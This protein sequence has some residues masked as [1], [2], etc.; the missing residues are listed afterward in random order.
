MKIGVLKEQKKDENRVALQPFQVKKLTKLG[1]EVFVETNAGWNSGFYDPEY[2]ESGAVVCEKQ[3][4]LDNA[5]LILKIKAPLRSEFCNYKPHHA[6]FTYL[7]F[8]ENM[9]PADITSIVSTG[10]TAIAYEWVE[11]DGRYPLLEPMS[12]LTGYLFAQKSVELCSKYK[13]KLCGCYEKNMN[14][15]GKM[16][17]I[18]IGNIGQSA[19]NYAI[20]NNLQVIAVD[21]N[22]HTINDRLNRRFDTGKV[23]YLKTY[24]VQV[25]KF[26]N[27]NP[28]KVIKEIAKVLPETDIVLCC[29]VRRPELPKEK[30]E[31]LITKEMVATMKKGSVIAD[32]TACDKDLI[33]TCV[34]T[35]ELDHFDNI[36]GI[37]HYS[38]D[39]IP[40]YVGRTATELLTDQTFKYVLE[41]VEKGVVETIKNNEELRKGVMCIKGVLTHK[42]S[43][44]K[45]NLDHSDISEVL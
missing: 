26:E 16:M 9:S 19:F 4:V 35:E 38:C 34:S 21:K 45:K 28:D 5:A 2:A 36:G 3:V 17:I 32:A 24:G 1:H 41:M 7:H 23:D 10:V 43:A 14:L 20:H 44:L 18:G 29:A 33:E 27:D 30:M 31:Y 37:I 6:L 42:Y 8:D 15:P 22:P 39:H 13:G 12:R 40:S 11:A 25:I